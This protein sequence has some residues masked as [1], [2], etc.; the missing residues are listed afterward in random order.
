MSDLKKILD[1]VKQLNKTPQEI[2]DVAMVEDPELFGDLLLKLTGDHTYLPIDEINAVDWS[3]SNVYIT[4]D[5]NQ[6][7]QHILNDGPVEYQFN[8]YHAIQHDLNEASEIVAE[9]L[10]KLTRGS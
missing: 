1:L 7:H 10:D 3:I 5:V 8:D 2:M 4:G 9:Y 6:D